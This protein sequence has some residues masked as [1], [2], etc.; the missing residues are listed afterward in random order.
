MKNTKIQTSKQ[1][2]SNAKRIFED[3]GI[4]AFA[5]LQ[6]LVLIYFIATVD[7]NPILMGILVFFSIAILLYV[8][9]IYIIAPILSFV[10]RLIFFNVLQKSSKHGEDVLTD[11]LYRIERTPDGRAIFPP[12]PFSRTAYILSRSDEKRVKRFI[13]KASI[14]G[15]FIFAVAFEFYSKK[16]SFV[17]LFA[18]I[19]FYFVK[20]NQLMAHS[21]K[22][23][24]MT[25]KDRAKMLGLRGSTGLFIAALIATSAGIFISTFP[26]P[27]T[28]F[29]GILVTLLFGLSLIQ[30]V[31]LIV[32]AF[33]FTM[34][35]KST[36]K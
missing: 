23:R 7:M 5:I 35:K 31:F 10:Y 16:V 2:T 36:F 20:I 1:V 33:Q 18:W 6:F 22:S 11:F 32:Y 13:L 3:L 34:K 21:E 29:L 25:L 27:A 17:V 12:Y 24:L 8:F 28:K 4:I 26:D 14:I 30:T 15:F 19:I 9:L